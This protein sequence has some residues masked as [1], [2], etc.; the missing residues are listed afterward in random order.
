MVEAEE[1]IE[2]YMHDLDGLVIMSAEVVNDTRPEESQHG[3]HMTP[4]QTAVNSQCNMSY[5]LCFIVPFRAS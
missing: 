2:N 4:G 3:S 1:F 5:Q